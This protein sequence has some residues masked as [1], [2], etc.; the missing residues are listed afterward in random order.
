MLLNQPLMDGFIP[1]LQLK[2]V[3]TET[4]QSFPSCSDFKAELEAMGI[5]THL[6]QKKSRKGLEGGGHATDMVALSPTP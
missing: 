6:F 3:V 1:T 2:E 4:A 5:A